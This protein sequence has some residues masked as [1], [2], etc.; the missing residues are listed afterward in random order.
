M[1]HTAALND[2]LSSREPFSISVETHESL[3][4]S[5]P[6]VHVDTSNPSHADRITQQLCGKYTHA[7]LAE[8]L[9]ISSENLSESPAG[10]LW[11][12]CPRCHTFMVNTKMAVYIFVVTK[13]HLVCPCVSMPLN[14]II[15]NRHISVYTRTH[16][17]R[18]LSTQT[19]GVIRNA[20]VQTDKSRLVHTMNI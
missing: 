14:S 7:L 11:P 4:T 8:R 3:V 18:V 6:A 13:R 20:A 19:R 15:L 9:P 16:G 1:C 17:T 5:E 2:S 12:F 10:Y